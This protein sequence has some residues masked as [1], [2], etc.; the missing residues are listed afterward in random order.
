MV[1]D[2]I[3][4][5]QR[6]VEPNLSEQVNVTISPAMVVALD[7]LRVARRVRK[8]EVVSI[9]LDLLFTQHSPDEIAEM[10]IQ[11]RLR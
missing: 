1:S 2:I 3:G 5:L 11:R 4:R 9:A 7:R 6:K 8:S 10:V